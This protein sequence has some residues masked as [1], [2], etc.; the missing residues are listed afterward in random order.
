[1]QRTLVLI[2]VLF[3]QKLTAAE[4]DDYTKELFE[5]YCMT[6]HTAANSG[7]PK[8]FAS[9]AWSARL[10]ERG[11]K[12]LVESSIEGIGNMPPQGMCMECTEQDLTNLV[13]YMSMQNKPCQMNKK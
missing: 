10:A 8:A 7:A 3:T 9:N 13:S 4:T 1:M 12:G 5:L 6:C 2:L 11:I